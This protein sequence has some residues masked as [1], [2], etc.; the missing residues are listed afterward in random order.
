MSERNL[1]QAFK[2][3]L[4]FAYNASGRND[5]VLAREEE[6]GFE[7]IEAIMAVLNICA[8]RTGMTSGFVTEQI[9]SIRTKLDERRTRLTD[10]FIHGMIGSEKM[11]RDPVVSI[12]NSQTNSPGAVQQIGVGDHFSQSAMVQ[13]LQ[14][15]VDAI[16]RALASQEF[17]R[18][19]RRGGRLQRCGRHVS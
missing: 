7:I 18:L 16:N 6:C 2:D 15:L 5:E 14:P 1:I 12:V 3:A 4:L 9:T 19:S 13:N 8:V 17:A 10:D 11:K